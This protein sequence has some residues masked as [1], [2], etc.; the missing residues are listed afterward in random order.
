MSDTTAEGGELRTVMDVVDTLEE[1]V[2][3]GRRVPFT[4]SI[5]VNEEEILELVDRIRVS[6]PEDLVA[7][8]HTVEEREQLLARAAREA[9]ETSTRAE[10]AAAALTERAVEEAERVVREAQ[11]RA[12]DLIAE[13]A[14]TR[15]ATDRARMV[16]DEAEQHAA[17]QRSAA[18]DYTR[19]VM[20][21]L[22]E[23]LERWLGTVREG[24]GTLPEA[25]PE[26]RRRKR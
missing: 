12:A 4:P 11:A 24:L 18:D 13:N 19:E 9:L 5:V 7:A 17:A 3:S 20:G 2:G 16:V 22:A 10:H 14:I 23:Q 6:L 25:P 21:R 26:K 8:Q 15:S 1:L